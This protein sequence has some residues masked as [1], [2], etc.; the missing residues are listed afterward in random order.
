MPHCS[1]TAPLPPARLSAAIACVPA[2]AQA[3]ATSSVSTDDAPAPLAPVVITGIRSVLRPFDL[4]ASI[5]RVQPEA[6]RHA[7]PQINLSEALG[8]VPGLL[9]RDRQNY[10][11]DVQLSLRGFG[12]RASF[13]IRGVRLLVDGIPATLP[14]GQGQISHADLGSLGRVEV[15]RGPFSVLYGNSSGGVLQ[16][17]SEEPADTPQLRL[18][19][20]SG[21]HGT[22]RQSALATGTEGT[23]GYLA[24]VSQ[25]HTDGA[26]EH[27]R[28]TRN[29]ANAKLTLA[30]PNDDRMTLVANRVDLPEAQD[31]LGLTRAQFDAAPTSAD[32]AALAFN[33]RKTMAQTQG[34]WVWEHAVTRALELRLATYLGHR[35][36]EQ[37]QAIP[38]GPQGSPLHPGGMIALGRDYHGADLRA[39][40][41]SQWLEA[42]LTVVTGLAWDGL[43]EQRQGYQNFVG[44]TLGVQGEL[45]RDETNTVANLDP[46]LQATWQPRPDWTLSAG[47]RHS[48]IRFSSTDHY[49]APPNPD[50]SGHTR[51]SATTPVLGALW[52]ATPQTHFYV[53][54]GR[55][56]ETPTLNELAYRAD[57]S[58]GLNLALRPARSRN[59]EAGLKQRLG[60]DARAGEF[61]L[62]LFQSRTQDELVT[63]TNAGGR[64]TFQN[65]SATRRRG[66]EAALTAPFL[67]HGQAQLAATWLDATYRQ[68]FNTCSATPC[69]TPDLLIPAGNRLPGVPRATTYAAVTWAPPQGWLGGVELRSFSRVMV[70]D[71]NSDAA[72]GTTVL[73]AHLGHRITAGPW[74]LSAQLRGDN[75]LAR[76]YAGSVIVNDGNGRFFEPAP[77]RTWMA[78]VGAGLSF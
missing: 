3:H 54:S 2:G 51:Y 66:L 24:S 47:L 77:G 46:Y 23:L 72:A 52:A 76:H 10:A 74:N 27:S 41:Q 35:D 78:S 44:S 45:R 38:T 29:L 68:A 34:G 25:F 48:R 31:P 57:G 20:A 32:P 33:T 39:T 30:L 56:F 1:R 61:T 6:E 5:S 60:P 71:L 73:A 65:A 15:L 62:A 26:R 53:A 63:Q 17:F 55:G 67:T 12:S 8:S 36:T 75:L 43:R 37:F 70:N 19:A 11:Q 14:D 58:T 64:A 28:T 59:L 9:A 13:G 21:S 22:Q 18:N 42:P 69:K 50:D 16:L 49:I 40:A 7:Q 4:P